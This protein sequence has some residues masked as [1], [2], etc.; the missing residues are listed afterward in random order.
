M[1]PAAFNLLCEDVGVRIQRF[2]GD[3]EYS[4]D[5]DAENSMGLDDSDVYVQA[6]EVFKACG[7][8][9]MWNRKLSFVA[10]VADQSARFGGS[11]VLRIFQRSWRPGQRGT[12]RAVPRLYLRHRC[13]A[14]VSGRAARTATDAGSAEG[15]Q[16]GGR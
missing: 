9:V 14:A 7:L 3:D 8:R 2:T 4:D 10:L 11:R 13:P 15:G 12:R 1:T 5:E 16:G 6:E